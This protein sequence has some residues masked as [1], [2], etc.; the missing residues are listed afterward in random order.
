MGFQLKINW[1]AG[2]LHHQQYNCNWKDVRC[3][4][5]PRFSWHPC[6]AVSNR[7][8]MFPGV[9]IKEETG[10]WEATNS[11]RCIKNHRQKKQTTCKP[12]WTK[13]LP[14][15]QEIPWTMLVD[16]MPIG[17]KKILWSRTY[18]P[19]SKPHWAV[20]TSNHRKRR[21]VW[22]FDTWNSWVWTSPCLFQTLPP[23]P[24]MPLASR[25][26]RGLKSFWKYGKA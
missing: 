9:Q 2:F 20:L 11:W 14:G 23:L 18:T 1:L 19:R 25:E 26:N 8:Y 12:L 3:W 17:G 16:L 21:Q 13:L 15:M 4:P 24:R 6:R 10:W 7:F 22:L 5:F